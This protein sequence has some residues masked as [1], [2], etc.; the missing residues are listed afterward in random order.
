MLFFC[1]GRYP[2]S[3]KKKFVFSAGWDCIVSIPDL[4]KRFGLRFPGKFVLA[5]PAR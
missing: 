5:A 1:A 2:R 4:M 3:G